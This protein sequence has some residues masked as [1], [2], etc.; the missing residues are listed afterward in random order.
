MPAQAGIHLR[1]HC[2]ATEYLDAGLRRHDKTTGLRVGEAI[3]LGLIP[4]VVEYAW[5]SAIP[6][7]FRMMSIGA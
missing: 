3:T 2:K 6:I 4:S 5:G 7:T 1:F